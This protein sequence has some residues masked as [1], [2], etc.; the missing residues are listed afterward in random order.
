VP[1]IERHVSADRICLRCEFYAEREPHGVQW[2]ENGPLSE[3]RGECRYSAPAVRVT[4]FG[5]A[6]ATFTVHPR[7]KATHWCGRF[8][9]SASADDL[10]SPAKLRE[11]RS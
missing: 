3:G 1:P 11:S 8:K 9:P 6:S 10:L 4:G 7:V 5:G 2:Y